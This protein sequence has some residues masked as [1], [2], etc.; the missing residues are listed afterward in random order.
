MELT[1]G[2]LTNREKKLEHYHMRKYRPR[3]YVAC[4]DF[5]FTWSLEEVQEFDE[6]WKQ[7]ANVYDLQEYFNRSQEEILLLALDRAMKG[8]IEPREGGFIGKEE[9]R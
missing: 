8:E 1:L 7:G 9:N 4:E 5:D 6:M 3:L 2:Q